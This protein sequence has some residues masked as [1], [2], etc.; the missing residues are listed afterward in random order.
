[1]GEGL[2]FQPQFGNGR[3]GGGLIEDGF[4]GSLDLV[5]GGLLEVFEVVGAEHRGVGQR[6]DGATL[7]QL[8]LA[9]TLFQ[10]LAA[11]AQRLVDRF[12]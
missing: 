2:D 7:Q 6:G 1:V 12:R 8:Q 3:G 5:L 11:A 4:F 10:P 9:Q